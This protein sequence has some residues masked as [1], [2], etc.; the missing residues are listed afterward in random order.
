MHNNI[1]SSI[2]NCNKDNFSKII[3]LYNILAS[4]NVTKEIEFNLDWIFELM[5]ELKNM[6][7]FEHKHPHHHLDVWEHTLYALSISQPNFDV[8]LVLLLHDI[9][10][11]FSYTEKDGIRHFDGHPKTSKEMSK[12]ILIRIGFSDEYINK[13]CYLIEY[14][15]TPISKT[16]IV[17]NYELNYL[18]YLI[19]ECDALAHH[20]DKLDKRIKY[21]EKT[22]KL[23]LSLNLNN[24][25]K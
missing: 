9:G 16:D 13:I 17:N 10:K 20:P 6:I 18:R 4:D 14:H 19:Q 2:S 7:C 11:P 23:I 21:L 1:L 8:R 15:D 5:P 25:Q 24:W 22:K 3:N 12:N